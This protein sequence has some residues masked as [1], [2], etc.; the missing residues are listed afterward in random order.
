MEVYQLFFFHAAGRYN[1]VLLKPFGNIST[2]E[3]FAL[4][5]EHNLT[6]AEEEW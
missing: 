1:L 3:E 4:Q 6:G 2:G 5:V